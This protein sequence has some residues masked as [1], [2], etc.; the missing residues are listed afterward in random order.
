MIQG[1]IVEYIDEGRFV[2]AICLQ[3]KGGRL[4]LL[5]PS[6]REV[7]LSLKG[8]ILISDPTLDISL[9]RND[10]LERLKQ[11]EDTRIRLKEQIDVEGLWELIRDEK[12]TFDHTYLAQLV[13]GESVTGNHSSA[14]I[15]ALFENRLY[16]KM[17]NGQFLPN[18]QEKVEEIVRQEAEEAAKAETLRQ[19]SQWLKEI[20]QGRRVEDPP[21]RSDIVQLLKQLALYEKEAPEFKVGRELLSNVGI[22]DIQQARLL[23]ITLGE[24]EE[25]ENL[26]LLRSGLEVAF[27]QDQLAASAS[28]T[29]H[30]LDLAGREDLR[31][32]PVLTIDGPLTQDFDDAIS[33]ERVGDELH[34][35]VHIADVASIIPADSTLDMAAAERASSQYLPRRQ[36]PMFPEDLSADIL[37]LRQGCDRNAISLLA[38]FD[39][40]GALLGYRFAPTVIRVRKRLMYE[41]VNK[42][43][44]QDVPL[45]EMRRLSQCLHQ[46]RMDQGA[47]NLSLP[48]L[49]VRFNGNGAL[50]LE[51][52][53]QETP[54]RVIIAEFMILYNWLAARFC[55][56]SQIPILFRSQSGASEKLPLDEKGYFY[57]VF[58]QRRKLSPLSIRTEPGPHSGLGVDAYIHATSPIRRYLDLVNQRQIHHYLLQNRA[59][60]DE[61]KLEEIRISAE[62]TIKKLGLIKRNRIRYWVLK[63]LSLNRG[64]KLRA[65]VL[66]ELKTKYRV[67]LT[68]FLMIVDLKRKNGVILRQGQEIFVRATKVDPW[69]DIISLE[70]IEDT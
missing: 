66:D 28:L 24:W 11:I 67:A 35:G 31:D 62:P 41:D 3:D 51:L 13:F 21:F 15:R 19:W 34:L 49:E 2:C 39:K 22:S 6:N 14:V 27:T 70:Y 52:V 9:P 60:Y 63:Y 59:I 40:F 68:D 36:I 42:A 38:R 55:M 32:L 10:L 20:Q 30:E 26:D 5:T 8:T 47:L 18:L 33:L 65:L 69:D 17:K 25:D 53:E 16:F 54:S 1:K 44:E 43:I 56:E 46:N 29:A 57:Y 48:E 45:K 37:S 23:L 12:E 64:K 61:K 58:Q 7:N 4:H 50:S